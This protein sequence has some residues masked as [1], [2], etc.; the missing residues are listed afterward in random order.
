MSDSWDEYAE[1]WDSNPDVI[2]YSQLAF[3]SLSSHYDLS[4]LKVLD[5]GCGTGLLT[6]K[7]A[8]IAASVL[9]VDTSSKMIKV[10]MNKRLTI[11][12]PLCGYFFFMNPA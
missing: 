1:G 2:K 6:E 8:S 10:L 4:G 12:S 11:P 9:A 3:D 7:I 5:F